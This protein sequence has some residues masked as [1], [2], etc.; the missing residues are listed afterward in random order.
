MRQLVMR[1]TIVSTIIAAGLAVG[2]PA[3]AQNVV[4]QR[5]QNAYTHNGTFYIGIPG[6][7]NGQ[8]FVTANANLVVWQS[9]QKDQDWFLPTSNQGGIA[10]YYA[11]TA[12]QQV[13]LTATSF[14]EGAAIQD[15]E[16]NNNDPTELQFW[17]ML[18]S[19]EVGLGSTYPNCVILWNPYSSQA[20]GVSGGNNSVK[21]GGSVIQW[22]YD[23]TAN[24]F[25]CPV[26]ALR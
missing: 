25:W 14:A 24:Q 8:G 3:Q 15:Q 5:L 6:G 13:C 11:D 4:E 17:E 10:D 20:I 23:G 19:S 18:P 7:P 16:C 21:N 1:A 22:N 9:S 2:T 26:A 12:G